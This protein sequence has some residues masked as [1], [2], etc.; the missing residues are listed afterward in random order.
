MLVLDGTHDPY[1][2]D[3][4]CVELLQQKEGVTL[5]RGLNFFTVYKT[6]DLLFCNLSV[7]LLCFLQTFVHG[8]PID[9]V[10]KPC[11]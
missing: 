8:H 7:P 9:I 3:C 4:L 11:K 10:T 6:S 1:R 2:C 5:V